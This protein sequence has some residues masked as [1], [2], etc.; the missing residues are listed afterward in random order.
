MMHEFGPARIHGRKSTDEGEAAEDHHL[1]S[2]TTGATPTGASGQS[3][4]W[5]CQARPEPGAGLRAIG[6]PRAHE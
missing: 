5:K 4:E 3:K 1:S 6:R 2:A